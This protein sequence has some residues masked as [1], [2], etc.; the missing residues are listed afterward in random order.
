MCWQVYTCKQCSIHVHQSCYGIREKFR[1]DYGQVIAP[2]NWCCR[3]CEAVMAG[4]AEPNLRY[5]LLKG[6]SR[7]V[8]FNIST[9]STFND[10]QKIKFVHTNPELWVS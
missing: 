5:S 7:L 4:K 10:F 6:I 8:A 2:P 3:K 9:R 1:D